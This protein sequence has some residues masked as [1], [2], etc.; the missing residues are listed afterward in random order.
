[1]FA[2]LLW[3]FFHDALFTSAARV[4]VETPRFPYAPRNSHLAT[5]ASSALLRRSLGQV[6]LMSKPSLMKAAVVVAMFGVAG[7]RVTDAA[8]DA[9]PG[10]ASLTARTWTCSV[11]SVLIPRIVWAVVEALLPDTFFQS[12]DD[13]LAAVSAYRYW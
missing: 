6:S 1:M 11:S 3:M 5:L 10:P 13:S 7:T 9:V 4:V 2:P 8:F 12:A